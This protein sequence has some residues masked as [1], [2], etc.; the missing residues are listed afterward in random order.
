MTW[1]QN[2]PTPRYKVEENPNSAICCS[3]EKGGLFG[4]LVVKKSS[5]TILNTMNVCYVEDKTQLQNRPLVTRFG[6]I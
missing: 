4:Y 5:E 6:S 2:P 3:A 1:A